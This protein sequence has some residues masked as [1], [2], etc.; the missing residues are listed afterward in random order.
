M[1]EG[2]NSRSI[3]DSFNSS[4]PHSLPAL[5]YAENALEP[6]ISAATLSVH[7][8]KHHKGY[9]DSLNKLILGT[10]FADMTLEQIIKTT[11]GNTNEYWRLEKM[12]GG[13]PGRSCADISEA[14][15]KL[16]VKPGSSHR[17]FD[18]RR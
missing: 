6:L 12:T 7:Y 16:E 14:G 5:P 8:G 17:T 3:Y 11:A 1:R 2:L 18:A 10:P 4:A 15:R 9:V 13:H